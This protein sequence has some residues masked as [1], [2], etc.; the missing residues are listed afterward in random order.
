MLFGV[1]LVVVGSIIHAVWNL[2]VKR[3]GTS[4]VAFVWLYSMLVTPALLCYLVLRVAQGDG[5]RVAS[6]WWAG[7]VSAL[8]H[9]TYA[10]VL[11]RSYAKADLGVVYPVARAGAPVLV[12]FGSIPL[13]Q[14]RPQPALWLGVALAAVG[15]WL[16]LA[17]RATSGRVAVTGAAA[18]SA[19]AA[20]IAGYTLWDGYAITRLDVDVVSYLTVGSLAQ[21]LVLSLAVVPK[22]DQLPQVARTYWRAALPVAVLVPLSYG[23]VLAA[24]QQLDV[25]GVAALRSTSIIA[26][27]VLGWWLLAEPRTPRRVAGAAITTLGVAIAAFG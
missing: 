8:L 3:S 15:V 22:R 17:S 1:V 20:T 21:L 25:Q 27:S 18:G 7:V 4:G 6:H 13:V 10:L 5:D 19:T 2:L 26:A 24:M 14:A 9:T 11:Q 12:A 23:L 16:L